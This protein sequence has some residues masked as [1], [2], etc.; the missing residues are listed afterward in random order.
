MI[1]LFLYTHFASALND[2]LYNLGKQT[3]LVTFADLVYG[4]SIQKKTLV[5]RCTFEIKWIKWKKVIVQ[6]IDVLIITIA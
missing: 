5:P 4:A 3:N 1:C 2:C 6:Y